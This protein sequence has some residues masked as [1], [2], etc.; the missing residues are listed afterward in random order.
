MALSLAIGTTLQYKII[1]I[2]TELSNMIE[3]KLKTL[4]RPVGRGVHV[5][6]PLR[7]RLIL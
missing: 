6:P 2:Y 4:L 5:H 3:D 7:L 1:T